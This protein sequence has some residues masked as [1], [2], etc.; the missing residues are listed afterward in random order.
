MPYTLVLCFLKDKEL[1]D[2]PPFTCTSCV[3]PVLYVVC[4]LTKHMDYS[5]IK[6]AQ[7]EV[8]IQGC[9]ARKI[10]CIRPNV[11]AVLEFIRTT[12]LNT[13]IL[14][15]GSVVF[16]WMPTWQRAWM[17]HSQIFNFCTT[18]VSNHSNKE[19]FVRN[20]E[21]ILWDQVCFPLFFTLFTR[22]SNWLTFRVL[23]RVV[24]RMNSYR[25]S[26]SSVEN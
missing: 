24:I 9:Y 8:T 6:K 10:E 20:S 17:P 4:R 1:I 15:R 3:I 12:L 13:Q 23:F 14:F 18:L 16:D 25:R 21:S 2:S 26:D 7:K 11:Q 5:G 19:L 22:V